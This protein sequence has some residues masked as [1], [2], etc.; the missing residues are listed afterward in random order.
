MSSFI[1]AEYDSAN[2]QIIDLALPSLFETT[3]SVVIQSTQN[4]SANTGVFNIK[5]NFSRAR[6][7]KLG[8]ATGSANMKVAVLGDSTVA[9]IFALSSASPALNARAVAPPVV[10][11]ALSNNILLPT[12]S[13]S[14][15]GDNNV[16][17]NGSTVA[18]YDPRVTLGTGWVAAN[19]ATV[20][21]GGRML[22]SG[23]V[24]GA[25]SFLPNGPVDTFDIYYAKNAGLG[26]FNISRTG[27]VTS[28]NISSSGTAG[29]GKVTFTGTRDSI[30]PVNVNWVSAQVLII[31]IVARDSTVK[32]IQVFNWGWSS[33]KVSDWVANTNAFDHLPGLKLLAP[34]LTFIS[35]GINEWFTAVSIPTYTTNLGILID[36][37]LLSGDVVVTTGFPTAQA[38]ISLAIQ[39]QYIAAIRAVVA[40]RP[41][42]MLNDTWARWRT[43][44]DQNPLGFYQ[45]GSAIAA[46]HP[47]AAGYRESAQ[48]LAAILN[49]I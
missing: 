2:N 28:G 25:L 4:T 22:S 10:L 8:V 18:A 30:N 24:T 43:Y 37:A 44:E 9:G 33:G 26:T 1:S 40:A 14:F 12:N 21:L 36:A 31:G 11:A 42:V 45:S 5:N 17:S 7:A 49:A 29:I 15:F 38:T 13:D 16:A 19:A 48:G 46:L 3:S 20:S 35:T 27:D 39:A 32:S 6:V 47:T 34:D 23:G 41:G